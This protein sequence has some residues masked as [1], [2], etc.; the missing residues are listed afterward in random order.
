M[1]S[2]Y[3]S[4]SPSLQPILQCLKSLNEDVPKELQAREFHHCVLSLNECYRYSVMAV[5]KL[6]KRH[7]K[8]FLN[9]YLQAGFSKS[10]LSLYVSES[11][12]LQPILQFLKSNRIIMPH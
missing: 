12:S 3:A 1:L 8:I 5:V 2:F 4:E 6:V 10:V 9:S 11:P 7:T